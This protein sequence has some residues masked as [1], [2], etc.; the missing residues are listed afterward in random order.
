MKKNPNSLFGPEFSSEFRKNRINLSEGIPGIEEMRGKEFQ[1]AVSYLP[2]PLREKLGKP[3][4]E[5]E[6]IRR[7]VAEYLSGNSDKKK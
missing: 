5:G 7:V 4:E 2:K 1:E 3:G 6:R